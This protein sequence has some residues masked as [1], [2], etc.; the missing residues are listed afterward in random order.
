MTQTAEEKDCQSA[1]RCVANP[2]M[3]YVPEM[4][5]EIPFVTSKLNL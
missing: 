1:L 5:E 2:D 4:E 3:M